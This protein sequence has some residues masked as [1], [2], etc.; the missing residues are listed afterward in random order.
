MNTFCILAFETTGCISISTFASLIC[1]PI[2]ITSSTIGLKIC[3]IAV[4]NKRCK[5]IIKKKKKKHDNIEMLAIS[6]LNRIEVLISKVLIDSNNS[7]DEFILIN[8]VLKGYNEMKEECAVCDSK[9]LSKC[10][11]WGSKKSKFIKMCN[12]W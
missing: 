2:G 10:A 1:I 6:K 7:H 8:N 3:A 4:G 11:V 12:V 5:S 9:S